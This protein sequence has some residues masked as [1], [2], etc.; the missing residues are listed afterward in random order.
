MRVFCI[1]LPAQKTQGI[2]KKK[3]M[4]VYVCAYSRQPSC[5]YIYMSDAIVL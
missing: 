4:G 1:R 2:H 5:M 3:R